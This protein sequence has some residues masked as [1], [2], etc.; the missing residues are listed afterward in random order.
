MRRSKLEL[1]EDMLH[2]LVNK[3][4]TVDSIAY[5]CNMDCVALQQRLFFLVKSGLVEKEN[6]KGKTVYG[7]TKR[8]LAIFKTL[9]I[10]R[11]LEKLQKPT[12][13]VAD[14]LQ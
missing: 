3:H 9:A 11:R 14:A 5:K 13:I 10:T 8:G 2:A 7:L 1:F 12:R 6:C 4:L